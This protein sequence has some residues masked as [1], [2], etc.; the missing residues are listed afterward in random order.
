MN[1]KTQEEEFKENFEI[2]YNLCDTWE[3]TIVS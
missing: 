1:M 3:I 2:E